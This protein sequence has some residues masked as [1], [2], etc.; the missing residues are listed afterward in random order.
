MPQLAVTRGTL[1]VAFANIPA[2]K[3][4]VRM[5]NKNMNRC[6]YSNNTGSEYEDS[7]ARELMAV[8]NTC[9]ALLDLHSFRDP[10]GLPFTICEESSLDL[11]KKLVPTIIST[12]WANMEPGATDGY[13]YALG[14]IGVCV[15]CGPISQSDAYVPLATKVIGQFLTYYHMAVNPVEL[16]GDTKEIIHAYKAVKRVSERFYLNPDFHNFQVL[17]AGQVIGYQD[18]EVY[19]AVAG[20]CIIFPRPNAAIGT[21]AFIL[22]R[23]A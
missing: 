1:H 20:D 12:N 17:D 10:A 19:R 23:R 5:V 7:R 8:L 13:M 16:A 11:A 14:K 22:G 2:I 15:E 18:N 6:F 3:Q 4:N 21:E 9:D